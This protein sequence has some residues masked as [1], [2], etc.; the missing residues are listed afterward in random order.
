MILKAFLTVGAL[1]GASR[2]LGFL[3][4]I[5]LASF[6]GT[7]AFADAFVMAFKLPNL[8]RRLFAEGAYT[9][10]FV[11]IYASTLSEKGQEEATLFA[12]RSSAALTLFL[13][14]LSV[15]AVVGM[16]YIVQVIAPGFVDD[17]EKFNLTVDLS[18]IMFIY[19][20]FM[21][22]TAHLSGILNSHKRFAVAAAAP[23]VLNLVFL[24]ALLII[25]P[26]FYE[27]IFVLAY[28]VA[29]AGFAQFL[30]VFFAVRR[31]P[32]KLAVVKPRLDR[33]VKKLFRL[34]GPG[35]VTG[36]AQQ[37]NLLVGS[38]IASLQAGAASYLYYAD[39][40]YQLPL[41]LVGVALGVVLLPQLSS[42]FREDN[43]EQANNL[44]NS[45]IEL[46]LLFTLPAAVALFVIAEPIIIG[47]FERGAF[48]RG[49]SIATS[50]ALMAYAI[51]LPSFVLAKVLAPGFFAQQNTKTPMYYALWTIALNLILALILGFK[52]GFVGIALATSIAGWVN[53]FLL[54]LGLYKR[55]LWKLSKLLMLQTLK[56]SGCSLAMGLVLYLALPW[57]QFWFEGSAFSKITGLLILVSIG[58]ILFFALTLITRT[59]S[60]RK[61][62]AQWSK[63]G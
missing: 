24:V 15:F 5:S 2:I 37:L 56:L 62:K 28:A 59:T 29:F 34:M 50:S 12:N 51:G 42:L 54:A 44:L 47:L 13:S 45:G 61:L 7:T 31:I 9:A 6:F 41:G 25:I 16:P 30:L 55:R 49:S 22:L 35:L 10:A 43:R 39:R 4:D 53:A 26:F 57:F 32:I 60:P 17:Q 11:P 48:D 1:T 40:V 33:A 63:R 27:S 23:V 36:G 52:W 46:A 14:L 58:A 18:R 3:R 8:F 20:L 19:L 38:A 21:A